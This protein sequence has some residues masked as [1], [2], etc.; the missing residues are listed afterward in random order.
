[1]LLALAAIWG[2]SFM[3]IKIAAEELSPS[4]VVA[5]RVVVGALGLALVAP[6]LPGWRSMLSE[7]R[8]NAVPLVV[9]GIVNAALPFWF[10][11][12]SEQRIDSGLAAVLQSS[13]TLFTALLA[14][15]FTSDRLT[16][17]RLVGVLV[18]FVGVTLLAGAQPR[19]QLLAALAVLVTGFLYAVG[20]VYGRRRLTEVT[21]FTISLGSLTVA[22]VVSLPFALVQLPHDVPSWKASASVV[23][24]GVAGLSFAYLLYFGLIVGAGPNYA[25]LVTYLVPALALGY[26]AVFLDEPVTVAAIGG[27]ALILGGVAL[28]SG[29]RRGGRQREAAAEPG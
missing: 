20:A 13:A 5:G 12:W 18:G 19:G 29:A 23:V 22:S 2:S 9:L 21:P 16:R 10:L 14:F 27:L 4:V 24:L 15:L 17:L 11:T 25:M 7:L 28:G 6:F 26:G 1:M 8:R 3:F